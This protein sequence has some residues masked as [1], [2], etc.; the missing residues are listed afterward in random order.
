MGSN[1]RPK[2]FNIRG[3]GPVGEWPYDIAGQVRASEPAGRQPSG[4]PYPA[5]KT[6]I[7]ERVT[8]NI[9]QDIANL[10]KTEE[11]QKALPLLATAVTNVANNPNLVNLQ[12]QGGVFL[13]QIIA[14]EIAIG[15]DALKLVAN[16]LTGLAAQ[17]ATPAAKPA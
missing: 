13:A 7:I 8:M 5:G 1:G 12:V 6:G 11:G 9:F 14:A 10:I 17:A 3:S 16:D 4:Q 2:D 15:Q